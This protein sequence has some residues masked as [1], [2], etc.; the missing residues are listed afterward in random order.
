MADFKPIL[1]LLALSL[2]SLSA[3]AYVTTIHVPAVITNKN[4][5]NLTVVELNVTSGHGGV[6]VNGPVSVDADTIASAQTAAAYAASFL[7][8]NEK[9]YNFNYT[10]EDS[11]LNVSGPSGGLAFTLLAVAAL[12]HVQ[13]A[14]NFTATGTISLNGSVGVIGGI[15]DKSAAAAAG[16]MRFILVPYSPNDTLEALLYYISQ[17]KYRIPLVEV[18]NVSQALPYALGQKSPSMLS[19]NLTQTFNVGAIGDSNISCTS[20]NTSAFGQLVN[21]T[22]N[23]TNSTIAS[24]PNNFSFAKQQLEADLG[25]YRKL[26]GNGFLYTAAD[27]SF[28]SFINAFA[29][30]NSNNYTTTAAA[31][32]LSNVSDYCSSLIPPPMTTNNYE[33][34]VGGRLRQYWANITLANAEQQLANEETTDD[35]AASIYTAASAVGWCR[36]ASQLYSIASYM[37]GD[38]VQ[39]SPSLR[40]SAASAINRARNYGSSIYLQSALQAYN[41][42]D[43]AT[44]LY[45]TAYADSFGPSAPNVSTPQLYSKTLANIMRATNGTWP[46]QFAS[47]AEFYFR[48]AVISNGTA[49]RSYANQAYT[50]SLLAVNLE[51]AD[52]TISSSFI[53]SNS[54]QSTAGFSRQLGNIEQ[55]ISQIYS[56]MLV[57]AALLFVVLV[58]LL[59]RILPRGKPRRGR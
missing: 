48:Q 56:L 38:Y 52:G 30:A 57:N 39:V 12:E 20:C 58:V 44:A 10:I 40:A 5:G 18:S 50:T 8:L 22:F 29:L 19:L 42:G 41:D 45:A 23:F 47:Q 9:S 27:L 55:E 34:V 37:G 7:G 54:S 31:N 35:I 4:I 17:Q 1:A 26:A 36:A 43:Y 24:I 53:V 21:S 14:Q 46:S 25:N 6:Q 16:G 11:S 15:T 33:F 59:V 49:E 13:L 2:L 51:S 32:L 3:N 28:L